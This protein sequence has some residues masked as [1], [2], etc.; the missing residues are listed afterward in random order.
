MLPGSPSFVGGQVLAA[1]QRCPPPPLALP[2]MG[3]AV[4]PEPVQPHLFPAALCGAAEGKR[5]QQCQEDFRWCREVRGRAVLA[6]GRTVRTQCAAVP[7]DAAATEDVT[8]WGLDRLG[9]QVVTHLAGDGADQVHGQLLREEPGAQVVSL[10]VGEPFDPVVSGSSGSGLGAEAR[11]WVG[12]MV[13]G[14]G[15]EHSP[16][17][18]GG[19]IKRVPLAPLGQGLASGEGPLLL[20]L[21]AEALERRRLSGVTE[22]AQGR[23]GSPLRDT[24]RGEAAEASPAHHGHPAALAERRGVDALKVPRHVDLEDLA[25]DI[26]PGGELAAHPAQGVPTRVPQTPLDLTLWP[27]HLPQSGATQSAKTPAGGE[28]SRQTCSHIPHTDRHAAS[29]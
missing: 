12:V 23:V 5:V 11:A 6:A 17:G 15:S 10:A 21:P 3:L 1:R 9:E 22:G 28:T 2:L 14:Y 13:L 19:A 16:L 27:L 24:D 20:P 18:A 29:P 8:A 26:W 7:D 25:D 4:G